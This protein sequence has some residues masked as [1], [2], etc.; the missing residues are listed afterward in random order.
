MKLLLTLVM[1]GLSY[2]A[3][4]G[5]FDC[6]GPGQ[7]I[8][9]NSIEKADKVLLIPGSGT[10]G[11]ILHIG[12]YIKLGNY[13][14]E[15]RK[16]FSQNQIPTVVL[17]ADKKGNTSIEERVELVIQKVKEESADGSKIL[18]LGHSLGGIVARVA[19]RNEIVK[20]NTVGIVTVSAP[21]QG[22][23]LLDHL[24]QQSFKNK[25]LIGLAR[26][27]GFDIL[28]KR[29]LFQ[30][31]VQNS[32]AWDTLQDK[33]PNLPPMFSIVT[34]EPPT[35]IQ[36][37]V[38]FF[39][40]PEKVIRSELISRGLD[41]TPWSTLNDGLVPAY[42]Q[43]WGRCLAYLELNHLSSLGKVIDEEQREKFQ[44]GWKEALLRMQNE[45]LL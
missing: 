9:R 45:G 35:T 39:S 25:I 14:Q 13:Y 7:Q 28:K 8:G 19:A 29:Y 24:S 20:K 36:R 3:M 41:E 11:T 43:V 10:R 12:D 5:P 44:R 17:P 23:V 6:L 34:A 4:A 37:L 21:N 27:F 16:I 42:S 26:V 15:I 31:T 1:M 2:V 40:Y 32:A 18:I 22:T 30:M 38:P 33:D